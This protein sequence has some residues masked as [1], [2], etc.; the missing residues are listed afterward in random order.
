[1]T[2]GARR[3]AI[4]GAGPAGLAAAEILVGRGARVTVIERMPSIGRKFL[5]AGRGGLNL[6]HSEPLETLLDR[7]GAA[8][9][10]L[11]PAIR[12]FPP[13]ALRDWCAGLGV[14][15]FVGSSGRVF[16][17]AMKASPL[18]RAWRARLDALG[19]AFVLGTRFLGWDGA[20]DV[21]LEGGG[22]LTADAVVLACGGASWPRLGSDGLWTQA[23]DGDVL[24]PF[25]PANCGF[26][27][28]WSDDFAAR[29]AGAPLKGAAFAHGGTRLRG[30]ATITR[31]GVEGGAI[32]ALS[33]GLR[34][35][36]AREGS[37]ALT[38]DLKPDVTADALAARVSAM[39]PGLST[40]NRLRRLGLSP[41]AAAL[42]REAEGTV[43]PE[44][45]ALAVRIKSLALR[46]DAP[47]G[48][49]RAISSAGGLR[50]DALD[51]RLMLRA[52]PGVFAAGEMLDWEA[53]TGGYLLTGCIA[54]GR[55]AGAAAADW[56]GLP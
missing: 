8:R 30:E 35:A 23:L 28:R 22:A 32:Y 53:P 13:E 3:A 54:T 25:A 24:A 41:L 39:R 37:A 44:P 4:V 19:A 20:G 33:A 21:R 18:L 42:L 48:L 51:E 9:P 15:T 16:P 34:D 36:V 47:M 38:V 52:R 31:E 14:E 7:Y 6:T 29:F 45:R 10:R 26:R 55:W 40:A 11:E 43:P 56:L 1:M 12:A 17:V 49:E 46:L 5:M 50:L 27:R 2:R